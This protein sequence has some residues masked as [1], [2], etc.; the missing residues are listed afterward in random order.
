MISIL[1]IYVDGGVK[2]N[3]MYIGILSTSSILPLKVSKKLNKGLIHVAEENALFH[4]IQL[5]QK[6]KINEEIVLH[7]DQVSIVNILTK[8]GITIKALKTFPKIQQIK[9]F[10]DDNKIKIEWIK[11]KDNPAHTLVTE[12]YNGIFYD[13]VPS[14]YEKTS[15]QIIDE[16]EVNTIPYVEFLQKELIKKDIL[17]K[18]LMKII[19]KLN[20]ST[21]IV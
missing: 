17:I 13:D 5:L 3:Y 4:C 2:D 1:P 10:I 7:C 12:A 9:N 14:I 16:K 20:N 18:D 15:S 11:G 21:A 19:S 8:N 6:L